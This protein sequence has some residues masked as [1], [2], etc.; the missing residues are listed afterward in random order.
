ML[1]LEKQT[2]RWQ[3]NPLLFLII[4]KKP[5]HLF[6]SVN[7]VPIISVVSCHILFA[8]CRLKNTNG[9]QILEKTSNQ[10]IKTH[11]RRGRLTTV[12]INRT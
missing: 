3:T 7:R 6:L 5:Y 12:N 11:I 8:L 1:I 4:F 10:T 9:Y 2:F